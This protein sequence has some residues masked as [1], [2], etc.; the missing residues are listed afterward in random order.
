MRKSAALAGSTVALGL[1]FWAGNAHADKRADDYT[2]PQQPGTRLSLFTFIGPGVRAFSDTRIAIEPDMSEL[3]VQLMGD[4]NWGFSEL[5]AHVDARFFL[6]NFGA[7]AGYHYD[8]HFLQWKPGANGNDL[9]GE[10]PG[11]SAGYES[12]SSAARVTKDT[13]GDF[14]AEAWPWVEGRV[15]AFIPGYNFMGLTMAAVRHE[16]RPDNG[17]DWFNGTVPTA[18]RPG[19]SPWAG[20]SR[21]GLGR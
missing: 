10:H 16:D 9:A 12:L 2:E 15:G 21:A 4:V 5:S 8:W 7:S 3:R 1:A 18:A 6:L 17:F 20:S 14:T 13:N 11:T 19:A